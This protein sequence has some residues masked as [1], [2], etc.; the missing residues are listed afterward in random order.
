MDVNFCPP[1]TTIFTVVLGL[2]EVTNQICILPPKVHIKPLKLVELPL[3]CRRVVYT[4]THDELIGTRVMR[5][6]ERNLIL[7][8]HVSTGPCF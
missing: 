7:P 2:L 6:N 1:C 5:R 4:L 8:R 3:P